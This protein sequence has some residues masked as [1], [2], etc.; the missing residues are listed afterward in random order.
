M[1]V[2]S[3]LSRPA[4]VGRVYWSDP[5][6]NPRLGGDF[7]AGGGVKNGAEGAI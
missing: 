4:A 7:F 6:P 2:R 1:H 3:G 5:P